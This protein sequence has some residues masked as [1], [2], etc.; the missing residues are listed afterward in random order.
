MQKVPGGCCTCSGSMSRLGNPELREPWC[1]KMG[2]QQSSL[3]LVSEEHVI[4]IILDSRQTCFLRQ[5]EISYLCSL[6]SVFNTC[7]RGGNSEW[8]LPV[9]CKMCRNVRAPAESCLPAA[10]HRSVYGGLLKFLSA[11]SS[12]AEWGWHTPFIKCILRYLPGFFGCRNECSFNNSKFIFQSFV[13]RIYK[14]IW[15]SPSDH[16]SYNRG[17]LN[18]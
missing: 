3:L 11:K 13:T 4:C 5:R 15:F 8:T 12:L 10:G 2:R 16:L 7:P 14:D 9:T 17:E 18:Y 1:F 6:S